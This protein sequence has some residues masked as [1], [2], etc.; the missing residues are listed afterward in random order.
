[1]KL[2]VIR[3][4]LTDLNIK[5]IYNGTIDEDINETG[6]SQAKETKKIMKNNK[7]DIIYC[8]PMLRTKHTCEI[9]NDKNV[10]IIYEDRLIER[11]L[12]KLDGKN[13]KEEGFGQKS[14]YNYKSADKNFEDLPTFFKRVHLALEEIIKNNKDKDILIV[15]HGG[16]LQAIYFYF[17][18]IPENGD[19]W[20][21][22]TKNCE[23]NTY[24]I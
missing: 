15:T 16:V 10:P 3:H 24:E 12:G 1:M 7:Y 8:S 21:F 6:I 11:S 17:N 19:L 23:I 22:E 13:L 2:Y 20:S 14:D 5:K 9:I 4:G 18:E